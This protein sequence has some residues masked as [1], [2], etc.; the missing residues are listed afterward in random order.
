M[1]RH[2][3]KGRLGS[4]SFEGKKAIGNASKMAIHGLAT[5]GFNFSPWR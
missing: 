2:E 4:P 3:E 5:P 1:A